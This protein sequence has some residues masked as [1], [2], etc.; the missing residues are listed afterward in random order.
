MLHVLLVLDIKN[1][2]IIWKSSYLFAFIHSCTHKEKKEYDCFMLAYPIDELM[3]ESLENFYG[4]WY[5]SWIHNAVLEIL[6]Q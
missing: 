5:Y 2:Q 6:L 4:I 1:E 3:N